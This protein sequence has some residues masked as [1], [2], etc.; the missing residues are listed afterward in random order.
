[1]SPENG[2]GDPPLSPDPRDG[3]AKNALYDQ[4]STEVMD[5]VLNP[6]SVC[7]D[8]GANLGEFYVQILKRAADGRHLAFEPIPG[9]AA[10]LAERFPG[11]DICQ[12]ALSDV[13][14]PSEF[15]EFAPDLAYSGLRQ[16]SY[17]QIEGAEVTTTHVWTAPLDRIV[18]RHERVELVKIDVEGGELGVLRGARRTLTHWK[19]YVIFEHGQGAAEFY[20]TTPALVHDLLVGEYGLEISRLDHW[21]EGSA[22]LDRQGFIAEFEAGEFYWLAHPGADRGDPTPVAPPLVTCVVTVGPNASDVNAVL[23]ELG[24]NFASIHRERLDVIVVDRLDSSAASALNQLADGVRLVRANSPTLAGAVAEGL[25]RASANTACVVR[26]SG[27]VASLRSAL[28]SAT[29]LARTEVSPSEAAQ[30]DW[31]L[32]GP[33]EVVRSMVS[34]GFDS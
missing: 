28:E 33:T 8:V 34:S 26:A 12:L 18:P 25:R 5:R 1:M 27:A 30:T 16:R 6:R 20:G 17:P 22:S 31:G 11:A 9:L 2:L 15:H 24:H 21:L 29:D 13:W 19:P 7:I 4:W 10:G 32:L 23:S 14:G 3:Y